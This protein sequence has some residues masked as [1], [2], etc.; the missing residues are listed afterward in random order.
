[1]TYNIQQNAKKINDNSNVIFRIKNDQNV[2]KGITVKT[3][4]VCFTYCI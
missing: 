4:L 1:M 3:L 2:E